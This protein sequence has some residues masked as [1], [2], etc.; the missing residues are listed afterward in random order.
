MKQRTKTLLA[1]AMRLIACAIEQWDDDD[2]VAPEPRKLVDVDR[3][4]F[5]ARGSAEIA[6]ANVARLLRS[7]RKWRDERGALFDER[8]LAALG[9]VDVSR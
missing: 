4:T 8:E 5:G 9:A 7:A 2:D 1:Q 6:R 3:V